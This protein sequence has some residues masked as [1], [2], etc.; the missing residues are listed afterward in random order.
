[1]LA[2]NARFAFRLSRSE[3]ESLDLLADREGL[4]ASATLRRLLIK[5]LREIP[6]RQAGRSAAVFTPEQ[7]GSRSKRLRRVTARSSRNSS[8]SLLERMK[9]AGQLQK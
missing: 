2:D 3:R 5:A 7:G 6:D 1:M 9:P 4:S 8:D